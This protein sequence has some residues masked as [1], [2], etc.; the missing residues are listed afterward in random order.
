MDTFDAGLSQGLSLPDSTEAVRVFVYA[1]T[2]TTFTL[3]IL[4]SPSV[5]ESEYVII[6]TLTQ[7]IPSKLIP[8]PIGVLLAAQIGSLIGPGPLS[9]VFIIKEA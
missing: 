3:Q 9:V 4:A 1:P 2:G 6:E 8:G 7:A 5:A